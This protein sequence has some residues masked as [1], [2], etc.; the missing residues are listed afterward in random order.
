M[1]TYT[2]RYEKFRGVDFSTDPALIDERRSPYCQNLISDNGGY[3]EKRLG[4]RILKTYEGDTI[5]GIF[6]LVDAGGNEHLLVHHGETLT[7]E[8]FDVTST[9]LSTTMNNDKST[10]FYHDNTLYILDGANYLSY[11]G[12]TL[13]DV[14]D[15]A[16]VPT[17]VIGRAPAGGGKL[18]EGA[19]Y[20]S[21]WR[22]NSFV[23]NGTS[24][25]FYLDAQDVDEENLIV[26]VNGSLVDA[27]DYTVD[28]ANGKVTFDAAPSDG[29]GVDNVVITFSKTVTGY[30]D[31]IQK[32]RFGIWFGAGENT[33]VFLSGNPD[34]KSWDFHSGLYDPTYFPDTGYTRIGSDASAIMGYLR[35]YD[36]LLVIKEDNDQDATMY[37]RTAELTTVE[38]V[39]SDLT[40]STETVA[41]FP[42]QQG[43]AGVGAVSRYAF[44]TL[45]DDPLFLSK[46]GVFTPTLNYGSDAQRSMQNRSYYVDARLTAETNLSQAVGVVWNGYYILCVNGVCFVADSR[47]KTGK[48]ANEASGYEWYYWTNIPAVVFMESEDEL[49]FGTA[50]GR[51]CKL[52]SDESTGLKYNDE[53]D[54]IDAFWATKQDDD[55]DF[56]MYKTMERLGSGVLI[57]PYSRSSVEISV[58]T[59][60]GNTNVLNQKMVDIFDFNNMDFERFTFSTID[61]PDV[62]PFG[63]S[64]KKY[65]TLQIIARNRESNEGFGVYGF[66][67]RFHAVKYVK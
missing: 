63:L 62:M 8:T 13:S 36:S 50:D 15:N 2:K 56:M 17:T 33:R 30:A 25:A 58:K 5:N 1:A 23:G 57:K 41:V 4:W 19:N 55:G 28:H 27:E 61:A 64:V 34:Y 45:R 51:L 16:F 59:D 46:E 3:P 7:H 29:D 22:K 14:V 6:R 47:Q 53:D 9:D 12:T 44:A 40:T 67:K 43:V 60:G 54:P 10:C 32:C 35:Q 39:E 21:P 52:R 11:D 37:I 66:V 18:L 42:I 20:L 65:K 38:T 26:Y 48:G 49:Y 24:T 31:T